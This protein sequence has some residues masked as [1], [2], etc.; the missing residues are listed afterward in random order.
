MGFGRMVVGGIVR[1]PY[2]DLWPHHFDRRIRMQV[3]QPDSTLT[4][5]RLLA[6][7]AME[8]VA[9]YGLQVLD[10]GRPARRRAWTLMAASTLAAHW[11]TLPCPA[12]FR[13]MALIAALFL[14]MKAVVAASSRAVGGAFLSFPRWLL[15]ATVW[16]GMRPEL[17]TAPREPRKDWGKLAVNGLLCAAVGTAFVGGSG[18]L[19]RATG[20]LL[21]GTVLFFIGS[22]LFVHYGLFT[23]AAAFWRKAGF[24]SGTLFKSPFPSQNLGE[25]WSRRWNLAFSEMTAISVYHP[26][27]DRLGR[28]QAL[29]LSFGLSGLFHEVAISLPVRAGFGL[30]LCYFL[31]HCG[32]VGL[33]RFL[34]G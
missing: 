6:L 23:L 11:I 9:G 33:E 27:K 26:L 30:P 8:L 31:L 21:L 28:G 17:F 1:L 15:F 14:G 10:P 3:F 4:V 5:V 13:M 18:F 19:W 24:D 34:A 29:F 20:S 12:G 25:F 7:L 22:S 2:G 32:L 16:P